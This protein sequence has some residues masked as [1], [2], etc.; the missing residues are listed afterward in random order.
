M[1]RCELGKRIVLYMTEAGNPSLQISKISSTFER[2]HIFDRPVQRF[3]ISAVH[4]SPIRSI[5]LLVVTNRQ[6]GLI[7]RPTLHPSLF[8]AIKQNIPS[9]LSLD[10]LERVTHLDFT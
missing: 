1:N 4:L 6:T 3:T 5:T 7:R 10:V 8:L 9:D 2:S